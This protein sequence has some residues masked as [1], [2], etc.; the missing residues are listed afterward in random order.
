MGPIDY[1]PQ[2]PVRKHWTILRTAGVAVAA[3]LLVGIVVLEQHRLS[4]LEARAAA[5]RAM[6]A[7][8]VAAT[9][10][11]AAAPPAVAPS[12]APGGR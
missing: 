2:Q 12:T 5:V 7:A 6:S 4:E 1:E 8:R 9:A 11:V 10:R 3:A